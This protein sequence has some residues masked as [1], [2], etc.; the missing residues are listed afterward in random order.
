VTEKELRAQFA[1][2]HARF[3]ELEARHKRRYARVGR[4]RGTKLSDETKAKMS[5]SHKRVWR[6]RRAG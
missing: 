6:E 2:L 4:P 5:E 1:K 3:D